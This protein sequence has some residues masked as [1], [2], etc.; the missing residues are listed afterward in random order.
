MRHAAQHGVDQSGVTRGAPVGLS[1]GP[2]VDA[3]LAS[4]A[5]PVVFPTV[6]I[7][8]DHLMDGAISGNTPILTAVE[9]GADRLIVLPT[10][11][12]ASVAR[13]VC[14]VLPASCSSSAMRRRNTPSTMSAA[15]L[16][17]ARPGTSG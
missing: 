5:I 17:A 15:I 3:I 7:G 4:A 1:S 6:E 10:G 16:R 14:A 12:A 9:L 8:I 11:F 2:A 13:P